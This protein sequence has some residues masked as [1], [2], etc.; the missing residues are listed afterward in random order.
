M[1]ARRERSNIGVTQEAGEL[2]FEGPNVCMGYATGH[3]DLSKPDLNCGVLATGDIAKMDEDG[4]F[5]I[6]GRKNRFL[7]L[8]G[9]R[10]NLNEVEIFLQ[11]D[12]FVTACSGQDDHLE[13][14]LEGAD[15]EELRNVRR[16]ATKFLKLSNKACRHTL[17][18]NSQNNIWKN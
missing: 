17:S 11:K 18:L 3:E 14:Y 1:V 2:I 15:L 13:I 12:G 16:S 5:Y 7:K 9:H 4:D 10:V 6:V 8:F